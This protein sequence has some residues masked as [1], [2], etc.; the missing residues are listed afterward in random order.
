[1]SQEYL[2]EDLDISQQR[3][4]ENEDQTPKTKTSETLQA[5]QDE[6]DAG[7]KIDSRTPSSAIAAG[8]DV[9]DSLI[10]ENLGSTGSFTAFREL[11]QLNSGFV[12]MQSDFLSVDHSNA[13]ID[14]VDFDLLPESIDFRIQIW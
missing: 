1:M 4:H 9:A 6:D 11:Y 2:A 12:A 13:E 5:H 8:E 7:P 14:N 10:S 3:S